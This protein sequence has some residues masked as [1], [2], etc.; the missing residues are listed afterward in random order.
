MTGKINITLEVDKV[1]WDNAQDDLDMSP[2]LFFEYALTMY[3]INNDEYSELFRKGAKLYSELD[4]IKDKMFNLE[5]DN[6]KNKSNQEAYDKSMITI[7]RIV[8][9]L[10][11]IGKNQLRKIA[12][13]N[14]LNHS[15]LIKYVE[16]NTDY[17]IT[18]C[19]DLPK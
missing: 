8:G 3:I 14:N 9:E 12:N 2:N 4:K 17:T 18:N 16:R 15:D 5:N 1:L 6:R 11:Y 7:N 10:G 19:G 13:Q